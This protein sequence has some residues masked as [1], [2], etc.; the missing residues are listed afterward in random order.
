M[1]RVVAKNR[2]KLLTVR[3]SPDVLWDFKIAADLKGAKMSSLVH[4]FVVQTI[5]DSKERNPEAFKKRNEYERPVVTAKIKRTKG[6]LKTLK[7]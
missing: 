6:R 2:E 1:L 5:R 7:R 3:V 4:M